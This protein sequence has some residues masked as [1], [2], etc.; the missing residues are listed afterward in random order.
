MTEEDLIEH[1][2]HP[3]TVL[4]NNTQ[5]ELSYITRTMQTLENRW[6]ALKTKKDAHILYLTHLQRS[7][8][9]IPASLKKSPE[10][11]SRGDDSDDELEPTQKCMKLQS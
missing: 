6:K 7:N 3:L 1:D 10:K 11:H 2:D 4:I 8:N 9:C 5:D